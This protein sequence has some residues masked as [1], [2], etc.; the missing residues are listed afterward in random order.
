MVSFTTLL[1]FSAGALASP[2]VQRQIAIPENW[3]W[4]VSGWGAGCARSGCYYDFNVTVPTIEGHIAGV[5]AYC[6]GYE[7]GYYRKGNW[8]QNCRIL[9]GVNNGVAA[10]LSERP[11]ENDTEST[12]P[13]QIL[14]SFEYAAYEDRPA[15]NFTGS[16][17][18]IYNQFVAPEQE[19]DVKPTSVFAVA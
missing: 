18:T 7:N 10:K 12:S 1:A 9:E 15:Y 19:F 13:Q 4:H 3:N 6:S 2:F 16:H 5:K 8:Y 11:P 17:K 14:I